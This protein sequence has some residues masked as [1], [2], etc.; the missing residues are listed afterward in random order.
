MTLHP[1]HL[2]PGL[3]I[4][5]MGGLGLFMFAIAQAVKRSL[6]R[7]THD[8]IIAQRRISLGF[9]VGSVIS[10]WTWSMAVML[11]SAS[12]FTWGTSGLLWFVVPNGLAVV[13]LVPFAVYMR[14]RM[15]EG[16][17]LIQFIRERFNN[18]LA[19]LVIF[20]GV[21]FLLLSTVFINLFGVVLVTGVIFGLN[22]TVALLLT[23]GIVMVYSYFGGLWTSTITATVAA[24]LVSTPA[25]IVVLYVLYKAG[26]PH[27]VFSRVHSLGSKE[28][29]LWRG[30]TAA[31]FGL[32]LGLGLIAVTICD[33]SF[34]QRIWG[35][36]KQN[37]S[38]TFVWAGW[39]FYP[40]PLCLGLIGLVALSAG[41]KVSD[42]GSFGA[43]G[44]GPYVISHIGLPVVLIAL[45][46][47]TVVTACYSAM[48]GAFSGIS[49]LVA[50]DVVKRVA[51]DIGERRLLRLT[52]LS[53]P[54]AGVIGAIV[55]NS[56]I[57][58]VSLVN[59]VFFVDIG[60]VVPVA[61]AIFWSRY[62]SWA[63]VAALVLA[64]AVGIPIRQEVSPLWGIIAVLATSTIVSVAVS[65]LS[66]ERF[67]YRR[68]AATGSELATGAQR[69]QRTP[70]PTAAAVAE[71]G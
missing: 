59:F 18:E 40:I 19:T 42:L 49:S 48:D 57:D 1:S 56:G 14:A 6:V 61:L 3:G 51:P 5:L 34:W 20:L 31:Q 37:L 50:V 24:L 63:F 9:G 11:S 21:L 33:Q 35:M 66:R 26:G 27:A 46:V 25:A 13:A 44:V 28:F 41:V 67:D 38:R 55:V 69:D 7:T 71:A 8:F 12:A 43:G 22:K 15:P 45:Y 52:K 65:L 16:Y 29:N 23:L 36:R 30:D 39:W 64:E 17:T 62:S 60:F 54:V 10:V 68:L 47:L 53:I 70:I 58:Y 4:A 2:S 32:S